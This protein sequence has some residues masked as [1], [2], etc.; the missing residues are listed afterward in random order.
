MKNRR[1]HFQ[2]RVGGTKWRVEMHQKRVAI[3]ISSR[4][5]VIFAAFTSERCS[6]SVVF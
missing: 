4:K 2:T 5:S 6:I 1:E 3:E